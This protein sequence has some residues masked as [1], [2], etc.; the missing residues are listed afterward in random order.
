ML[1]LRKAEAKVIVIGRT[2][3]AVHQ[4]KHGYRVTA[5][6]GAAE[7]KAVDF[8]AVIIPGGYART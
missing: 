8:E 5:D 1:R 7:A 4:S 6:L 2:R 3:G